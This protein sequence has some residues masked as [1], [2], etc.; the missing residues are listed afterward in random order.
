QLADSRVEATTFRE[1]RARLGRPPA[2]ELH[3]SATPTAS[4]LALPAAQTTY[5][6][7]SV[8]L[9][10]WR[11]VRIR[12]ELRFNPPADG[13][14]D[15]GTGTRVF[16]LGPGAGTWFLGRTADHNGHKNALVLPHASVSQQCLLLR[17]GEDRTVIH[18]LPECRAPVTVGLHPL[19]CG[20]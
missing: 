16:H 11:K 9:P 14:L 5:L 15:G 4:L 1:T 20:E 6:T 18:R 10:L 13:F 17:V 7:G 2:R 3:D 8:H 12:D 19:E